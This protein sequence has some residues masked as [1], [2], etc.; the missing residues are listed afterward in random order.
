MP[1]RIKALPLDDRGYPIPFF[2]AYIDGK[3]E[4]RAADRHKYKKCV[5]RNL[6]WVCGQT[7]TRPFAFLI[8]PMCAITRTTSEPPTHLDCAEWSAKGC[9]FLSKPIMVRRTNN[10]PEDTSPIGGISIDRNPGVTCMWIAQSYKIFRDPDGRPLIE[11]GEPLSLM[12]WREGRRATKAEIFDSIETGLPALRAVCQ[13]E[14]NKRDL[15][16]RQGM[17]LESLKDWE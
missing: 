11:V 13:N 9:P 7:L 12:W 2:V 8:G 10:M 4:F 1:E 5:T 15:S 6:C 17:L 16:M 3:P 14:Q